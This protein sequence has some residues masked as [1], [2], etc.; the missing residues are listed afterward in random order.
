MI[1]AIPNFLTLCNLL[2]GCCAI[3]AIFSARPVTT[4]VLAAAALVLDFADGLLARRLNA[5]SALGIQLDSLADLISFGVL[6]SCILFTMVNVGTARFP[7]SL[8]PYSAFVIAAAC[9]YRLARFNLDTRDRTVFYGLPSPSAALVIFGLLLMQVS[10]HAWW[11]AFGSPGA[12]YPLVIILPVLMLSDLRLW[13][14]K[15]L[16]LPRGT[17][18]LALLVSSFAILAAVTGT[19]SV[20]LITGVYLVLGLVNLLIKVY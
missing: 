4:L 11:P 8:L 20:V 16:R 1:R 12:L 9:A 6:P 10:N 15:G 18:I 2:A 3:A 14:T 7:M 5:G 19:A 17:G 13:N